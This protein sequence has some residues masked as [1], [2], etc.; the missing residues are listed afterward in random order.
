MTSK[1]PRLESVGAHTRDAPDPAWSGSR[2]LDSRGTGVGW[3]EHPDRASWR[4]PLPG[5]NRPRKV[6]GLAL[7]RC[8][9]QSRGAGERQ[10]QCRQAIRTEDRA[11]VDGQRVIRTAGTALTRST[12]LRPISAL[13][14]DHEQPQIHHCRMSQFSP[15]IGLRWLEDAVSCGRAGRSTDEQPTGIGIDESRRRG[16]R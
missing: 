7:P 10:F 13:T 8:P 14:A 16:Y 5:A 15:G 6:L 11:S 2:R 9:T 1:R 4:E 3:G 12:V